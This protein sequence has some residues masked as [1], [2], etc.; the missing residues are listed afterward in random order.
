M[1]LIAFVLLQ[2]WIEEG[3][4]DEEGREKSFC[5]ARIWAEMEMETVNLR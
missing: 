3:E 2:T 1:E 5:R 4:S